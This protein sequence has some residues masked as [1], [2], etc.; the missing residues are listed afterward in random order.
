MRQYIYILYDEPEFKGENNLSDVAILGIF[1]EEF[2]A[3]EIAKLLDVT[4]DN[5]KKHELKLKL[6]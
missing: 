5:I 6:Y 2:D 3:K 1:K 4:I